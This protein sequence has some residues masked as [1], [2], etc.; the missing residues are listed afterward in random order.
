VYVGDAARDITAG[1]AAGLQTVAALYGYIPA[2]ENAAAW[3]ADCRI[4]TPLE[5]L[6]VLG[7]DPVGTQPA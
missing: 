4:S 2:E 5:L 6:D 3:G 7:L 1:R